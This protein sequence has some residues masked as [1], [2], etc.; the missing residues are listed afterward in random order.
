VSVPLTWDRPRRQDKEVAAKLAL[1]D[2]ARAIREDALR[3][4][5]AE[6][7]V[8]LDEWQNGRERLV[9][10]ADALV[11]LARERTAASLAAYRG[12]KG[13]LA[14]VLSARR[15]ELDVRRSALDLEREVARRWAEMR[16]LGGDHDSPPT[17]KEPS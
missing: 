2:Q 12:G 1:V 6:V 5:V 3:A 8:M 13:A 17:I 14:D 16:F 7:T 9:L 11:P 15:N 4:H 10:Y